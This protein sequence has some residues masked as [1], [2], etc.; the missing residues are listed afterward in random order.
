MRNVQLKGLVKGALFGLLIIAL[1]FSA[2]GCSSKK[3]SGQNPNTG[4]WGGGYAPGMPSYGGG[5]IGMVGAG[6][7]QGGRYMVILA[8][9]THGNNM[10]TGTGPATVE[11]QMQVY[12]PIVCGGMNQGLTL[13]AGVY[14][15][16]P[17][18]GQQA[19][20]DVD[21]LTGAHLVAQGQYAQA[22]IRVDYAR[23]FNTRVC[24]YQ[25]MMGQLDIVAVNGYT[26]GVLTGFTDQ[27]GAQMCGY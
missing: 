24:G 22:I 2:I 7:D 23:Y 16:F 13:P 9:S 4:W 15:L 8:A 20:L 10:G 6:M 27:V 21:W 17:Q 25:G 19:F 12:A 18:N 11:G 14:Q 26:C 5:T 1:A 3:N